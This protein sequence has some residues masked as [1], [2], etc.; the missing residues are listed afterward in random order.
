MYEL[1]PIT[2]SNVSNLSG[3]TVPDVLGAEMKESKTGRYFTLKLETGRNCDG[4]S[5]LVTETK[6][7]DRVFHIKIDGY[8]YKPI[9]PNVPAK[10]YCRGVT[11]QG[12]VMKDVPIPN[13]LNTIDSVVFQLDGKET[14]YDVYKYNGDHKLYIGRYFF[15]P[16]FDYYEDQPNVLITIWYGAGSYDYRNYLRD[17][18]EDYNE[19][20]VRL[21]PRNIVPTSR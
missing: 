3:I 19:D 6:Q 13:D 15:T 2:V 17:A 10:D 16:D 14:Q 20:Y 4:F 8:K 1:E 11:W 5:E 7:I 18:D 9:E 12:W 21:T